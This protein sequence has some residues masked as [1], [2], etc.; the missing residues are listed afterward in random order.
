MDYGIE[1]D[2]N[3][4]EFFRD[5]V[6]ILYFMF[7]IGFEV[8]GIQ[9]SIFMD[10]GKFE[11]VCFVVEWKVVV[12]CDQDFVKLFIFDVFKFGEFFGCYHIYFVFGVFEG[13][14]EIYFVYC[15]V[16]DN[17]YERVFVN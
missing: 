1:V 8:C 11:F 13:F 3:Y 4:F 6:K 16:G 10:V 7:S 9:L 14:L 5:G 15:S 2:L 12:F 17:I